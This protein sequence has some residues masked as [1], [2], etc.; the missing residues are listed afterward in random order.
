[1]ALNDHLLNKNIYRQISEQQA[2][3][4]IK[5]IT[6][7]T[8]NFSLKHFKPKETTSTFLNRSLQTKDPFAYFYLL[9][10]IHKTPLTTR[11]IIIVSG[12]ICHGLGKWTDVSLQKITQHL[13]FTL[14]SSFKLVHDIRSINNVSTTATLFTM[15]AISMYT[16]IDTTHTLSV[17]NKFL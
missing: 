5:A 9:A 6:K 10:K 17:I 4:R 2:E 12:S 16:N 7:L 8:T 1:M 13:P 15:D 11:P 14:S 3:G